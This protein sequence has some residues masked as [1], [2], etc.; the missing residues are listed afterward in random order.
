MLSK[1]FFLC[2]Y[3]YLLLF[4]TFFISV[5]RKIKSATVYKCSVIFYGISVS[6]S[7]SVIS[8]N[9][10]E[11]VFLITETPYIVA[12]V[13]FHIAKALIS[14]TEVMYSITVVLFLLFYSLIR[15][16]KFMH[17]H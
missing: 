17:V 12:E 15:Y 8:V 4:E 3:T 6:V 7:V 16:N 14:L 2:A 13:L 10:A 11:T 1:D 9:V 5:I